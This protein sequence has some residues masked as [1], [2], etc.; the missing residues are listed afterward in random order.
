MVIK[1]LIIIFLLLLSACF[2]GLSL[3]L[4]SLDPFELNRKIKLGDK[5]AKKIYPLRKQGNL[6][7][8]TL[9]IGNVAVNSTLAVF[10]SSL[11]AGV[12]AG[13]V[14]TALIVVFGEIVP[15]AVFSRH[16]LKFGSRATWLVYFFLYLFY[17]VTKPMALI[18]D[19]TLGGELPTIYSKH[20]FRLMLQEQKH[21]SRSDLTKR[22]FAIL[23]RSLLFSD[24]T[25]KDIMTPNINTFLV[26]TN[27][28]VSRAFLR[29]VHQQGHSRIPVF[30][31]KAGVVGIL[32]SKDLLMVDPRTKLKTKQVMREDVPSINEEDKLDLV[33]NLFKEKK[34]HLFIVKDKLGKLAG[35]VTLE[36]VIEEIVGEIMDEYD[37]I[38]DMRK[39]HEEEDEC[40]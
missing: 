18:L 22:E 39:A 10:L 3:G 5:N 4:M 19:K 7:L 17:P 27:T 33:L 11:T 8:S 40:E 35:I 29:K 30:E 32:Y 25:V 14:S 16:A 36:D 6:L 1:Y 15:Q 23:E 38:M 28:V 12:V 34:V 20:E 31:K 2:S 13:F 24:K 37:W 26:T 9:L 21:L